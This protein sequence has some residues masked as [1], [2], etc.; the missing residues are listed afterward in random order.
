MIAYWNRE[1]S[2]NAYNLGTTFI[3]VFQGEDYSGLESKFDL[4]QQN[5]LDNKELFTSIREKDKRINDLTE[6]YELLERESTTKDFLDFNYLISSFKIHYP[7][8]STVKINRSFGVDKNGINDTTYILF[9]HFNKNCLEEN[10]AGLK[11]R[12]SNRLKFELNQKSVTK[13]DSIPVIV[14]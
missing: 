7:E 13:Q 1:K 11:S 9:V 8:F 2:D 4:I 12:L 5:N 3:K 14:F 6:K 10:K